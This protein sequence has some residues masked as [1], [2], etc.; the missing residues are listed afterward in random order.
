MGANPLLTVLMSV[1]NGD[2]YIKSAL[3][4]IIDQIYRNFEILIIDDGSTD[5]TLNII[6]S[7]DDPRIRI[8][9]NEV[10]IGLTK[11]LNKG[12]RKAKGDFIA[13]MDADDISRPDRL[14]KQ[15]KLADK[16]S[17][18]FSNANQAPWLRRESFWSNT[19][20][21]GMAG[22]HLLFQNCI[23]HSSVIFPNDD[24]YYDERYKYAQDYEL[25]LRLS[26]RYSIKGIWENLVEIR[27]SPNSITNTNRRNQNKL[28]NKIIKEFF[29]GIGLPFTDNELKIHNRLM[30]DKD[31]FNEYDLVR[32]DKW[33]K[34]IRN[35]IINVAWYDKDKVDCFF[36]IIR[37][38]ILSRTKFFSFRNKLK[39]VFPFH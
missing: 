1:Y 37:N 16:R 7:Y 12:I 25:W 11:S 39:E 35:H 36:K 30:N 13:R 20:K 33:M 9:E 22:I 6:H 4:S 26:K 32:I 18:V 5:N 23:P 3:D 19:A 10:N 15:I 21:N 14:D 29:N 27:N 28:R 38:D 24:I 2:S 31:R 8:I 17:I 34:K